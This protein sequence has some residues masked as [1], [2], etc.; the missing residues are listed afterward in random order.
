MI[1]NVEGFPVLETDRFILR[2][3]TLDDAKEIYNYF[4]KDEVTQY[5]DLDSF[6]DIQQ[7][8]NLIERWDERFK[9]KQS[10]RWGIARREDNI[11]MGSCG[12]HNW[13]H[14][15]FKAEIGYELSP[16]Y[17]R[18]G[19]MTEVLTAIIAYGFEHMKLHR[20]EALYDPANIASKKSLLKAGFKYEGLLRESFFEKG[21]FVDAEICSLL[22][23]DTN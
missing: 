17:W 3:I 4:S 11:M 19:V 20:I 2:R 21:R 1:D 8:I 12:Y 7:A 10:I 14:R 13:A 18:Q 6:T 5:Y 22:A 9:G 15:N 16:L 23:S